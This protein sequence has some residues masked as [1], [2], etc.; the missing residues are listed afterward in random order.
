MNWIAPSNVTQVKKKGSRAEGGGPHTPDFCIPDIKTSFC[1]GFF[2]LAPTTVH[3]P[4]IV[5]NFRYLI[6][7]LSIAINSVFI[8]SS[9]S[10]LGHYQLWQRTV[11]TIDH[12]NLTPSKSITYTT[13]PTAFPPYRYRSH[14]SNFC[15]VFSSLLY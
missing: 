10:P 9:A 13:T 3:S 6:A 15:H 7:P 14:E 1:F 8:T 2:F 12:H 4:A 11:H 5:I